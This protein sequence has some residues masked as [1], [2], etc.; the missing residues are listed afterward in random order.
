VYTVLVLMLCYTFYKSLSSGH[1]DNQNVSHHFTKDHPPDTNYDQ[2][3][4]S[5]DPY[6]KDASRVVLTLRNIWADIQS[7]WILLMLLILRPHNI[8]LVAIVTWQEY[9]IRHITRKTL[10]LNLMEVILMYY[11]MGQAGF[12]YQVSQYV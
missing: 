6:N 11:W 9:I 3:Y 7:A 5:T 8:A 12:Y 10:V 2:Q 1:H 4:F